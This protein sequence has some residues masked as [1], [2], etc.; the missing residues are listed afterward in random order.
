[1]L[2]Q[3]REDKM[4]LSDK[5]LSV[6]RRLAASVQGKKCLD[7]NDKDIAERRALALPCLKVIPEV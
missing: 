3:C 7:S 2:S 5:G 6:S 4:D 1:M